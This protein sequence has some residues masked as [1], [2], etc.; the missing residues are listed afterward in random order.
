MIQEK[1][2]T[3]S[4]KKQLTTQSK[5]GDNNN[6]NRNDHYEERHVVNLIMAFCNIC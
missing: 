4:W 6:N 5:E 3:E 2:K 1:D